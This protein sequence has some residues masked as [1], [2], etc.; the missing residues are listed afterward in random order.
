MILS[1]NLIQSVLEVA[2]TSSS[3]KKVGALLLNKGKI[4]ATGQNQDRKTH[5]LQARLAEKV[6][7]GDK[8]YLHAEISAL[9]RCK[10]DADTVVV[11]RLGGHNHDE[12]RMSKPCPI[13]SL[14]LKQAGINKIIYTTEEGFLQQYKY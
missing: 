3:R 13:C 14:A 6:G 11:A 12:L 1:D 10:S 2:Q 9:V 7:L 4:V 8:I 5:P